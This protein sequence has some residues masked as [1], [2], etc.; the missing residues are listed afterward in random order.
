MALTF[1]TGG[2][3][4]GKSA[5]AVALARRWSGPVAVVATAEAGDADMA[6]R[7]AAHRAERP[8]G[9]R[10]VEEPLDLGTAL[11]RIDD[12]SLVIVDCLAL[13][14]AN[15]LGVGV[16]G[17]EIVRRAAAAAEHAAARPAPTY[18][19]SNEVGSGIVPVNALAREYSGIL[20]RV[21]Q[22][23]AAASAD[24]LLVVAGRAVRLSDP[25]ALVAVDG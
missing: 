15:L 7:I 13:W 1:L 21:N 6:A 16:D 17:T 10:T 4:S 3:R 14:V 25:F 18:G 19:V 23:W 12:A 9:W 11:G 8:A 22:R 2:V 5:L 24:A 20:G